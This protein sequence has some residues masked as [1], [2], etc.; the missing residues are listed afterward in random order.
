MKQMRIAHVSAT[1]PPYMGGTGNVCSHTARELASRGHRVKVFTAKYPGA[2]NFE[3]KEDVSIYRISPLFKVG[4]AQF[5]PELIGIKGFDLIHLHYPFYGGEL[6]TLAARINHCPLVITYHQ[7]VIL[8]GWKSLVEKF[9]RWTVECW[10]L[11]SADI[12][13]FTS[14]DY[15]QI[16]YFRSMLRDIEDRID[17]LP[18]GVD[19]DLFHPPAINPISNRRCDAEVADYMVLMVASLDRAHY[20]KGVEVFLKSLKSLPYS[21]KGLVIGDGDLRQHYEYMSKE[22]NL[23]SRISFIGQVSENELPVYYQ[24]AN[25]TVLP[26]VTMGE[27]F[28]L[29]LLESLACSTPVIASNLPGVR[30]VVDDAWDGF[31][32]KPGDAADL[33]RKIQLLKENPEMSR[34]MGARGRCKV[35]SSYSWSQIIDRLERIYFSTLMDKHLSCSSSVGI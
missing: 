3:V 20:F 17:Y 14:Q 32:V 31:L 19:K 2:P 4:N 18:N 34:E 10:V 30:T 5:L 9:L 22:L 11:R 12:I 29:V 26:S 6:L 16:S 35:E 21:I 1:F 7:D 25:V 28:G 15:A 13:L 8:S 27:A 23:E 24:L 33:S